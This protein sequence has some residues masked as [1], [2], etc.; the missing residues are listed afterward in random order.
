MFEPIATIVVAAIA[1]FL[2]VLFCLFVIVMFYDQIS[3][4]VENLSTIDKL[5]IKR[6][7]QQGKKLE[8][9]DQR[10]RS[11]WQNICE[12][13]TGSHLQGVDIYWLFPTDIEYEV[14]L[15]NEY[16]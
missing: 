8:Q 3:C 15:E 12:V 2:A 13:M 1:C 9:E 6:A 10:S 14:T 16:N 4:I 7:R 11:W 5:K